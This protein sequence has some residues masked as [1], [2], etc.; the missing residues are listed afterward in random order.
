VVVV[1]MRTRPE[2]T[3]RAGKRLEE[4]YVMMGVQREVTA[5]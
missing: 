5:R 2:K 1:I 3:G 4:R